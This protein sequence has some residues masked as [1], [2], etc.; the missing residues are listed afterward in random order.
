MVDNNKIEESTPVT[1]EIKE[2]FEDSVAPALNFKQ[3]WTLWEFVDAKKEGANDVEN[4]K[5]QNHK[6]AW[7]NDAVSFAKVYKTIPHFKV[8]NFFYNKEAETVQM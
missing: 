5:R 7:F 2:T 6:V 3:S 1:T 4:F 8:E